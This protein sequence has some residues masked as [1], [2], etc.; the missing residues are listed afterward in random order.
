MHSARPLSPQRGWRRDERTA[1]LSAGSKAVESRSAP[2][3]GGSEV[4]G[5]LCA[6]RVD[7]SQAS[8][9]CAGIATGGAGWASMTCGTARGGGKFSGRRRR[10]GEA[11]EERAYR[12]RLRVRCTLSVTASCG[13]EPAVALVSGRAECSRRRSAAASRSR[14]RCALVRTRRRVQGAQQRA[15]TRH[16]LVR[17]ARRRKRS[18][19]SQAVQPRASTSPTS[20]APASTAL[21]TRS[22]LT[23]A[24]CMLSHP[25]PSSG[26]RRRPT[27]RHPL[28]TSVLRTAP[29]L[30]RS[31]TPGHDYDSSSKA[32]SVRS[33]A[34]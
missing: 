13:S 29:W 11:T 34:P 2:A 10:R 23:R 6:A 15:H 33:V 17:T 26:P 16:G 5:T 3:A 21:L 24:P 1:S 8:W 19:G 4:G 22:L 30:N 28:T 12:V 14:S 18:P 9:S 20:S 27:P 32:N 25:P 31:V 7:T